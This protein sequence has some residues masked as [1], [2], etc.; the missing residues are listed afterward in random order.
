M[1]VCC[2]AARSESSGA[3]AKFSVVA[4]E[5]VLAHECHNLQRAPLSAPCGLGAGNVERD[6]KEEGVEAK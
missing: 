3:V 1:P 4:A 2:L 6:Q 5:G